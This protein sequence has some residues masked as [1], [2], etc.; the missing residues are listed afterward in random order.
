MSNKTLYLYYFL[1]FLALALYTNMNA[2]PNM[3]IRM[4]YLV[5]LIAPLTNR[6]V[7]F[8]AIIICAL[9]IS[10]NTFAYPLMPTEMIYY[11]ILAL[12]IAFWE[13]YYRD[14]TTRINPLFCIVLI[15]VGLNDIAMQGEFSQMATVFFMCIL[16]FMCLEDDI[17]YGTEFLQISF[18]IISLT[19]SYWVL[20][21]PD[22][23][24]N[25]Y[26]KVDGVEQKGWSDPNYLSAALGTGLIIAVRN[27]LK[28]GNGLLYN[29][30]LSLT[31]LGSSIA[32]LLLASRGAILSVIIATT[33]L[34]VLS[35]TSFR[36]KIFAIITAGLFL[37]FLYT[38]QYMDFLMARVEADDGTGGHRTGIWQSKLHDFFLIENPQNWIFGVGQTEGAKL[39]SYLG[40]TVSV[41]STHND[42][43]SIHIY[44]GF[45]GIAFFLSIIAYPL[46]I[47]S[48]EERPYIIAL[49]TYLLICSM[50]IEPLAHGNFVYWGFLFYIMIYAR[51]SRE[52]EVLHEE[53]EEIYDYEE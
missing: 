41:L 44:Y 36:T 42:Y 38:N 7:L 46:R 45:I 50:T 20:F 24:V 34:F 25:S 11:I 43:L 33:A 22:A 35:K 1:L 10:K 37:L 30:F 12:A 53:E 16:L 31:I 5:A 39:G 49:L 47:C 51:Q 19:I 32:M 48:K 6:K 40:S 13:L 2:S 52:L 4:G 3:L 17:D 8:P 26:N 14:F 15:Y 23:Q 21:C 9:G 18:I 28:G 29:S 27:L